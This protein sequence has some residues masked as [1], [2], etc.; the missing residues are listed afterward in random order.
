MMQRVTRVVWVL[1]LACLTMLAACDSKKESTDDKGAKATNA[2]KETPKAS[3]PEEEMLAS[4]KE[5]GDLLQANMDDAQK[6]IDAAREYH[7]KNEERLKGVM[8]AMKAKDAS[9]SPDDQKKAWEDFAAR[10]EY[11]HFYDQMDQFE[12]RYPDRIVE[13]EELMNTVQSAGEEGRVEVVDNEVD[14]AATFDAAEKVYGE[15]EQMS[16]TGSTADELELSFVE[17]STKVETAYARY[18]KV[19]QNTTDA[20]QG[21]RSLVRAAELH[22]LVASKIEEMPAV[23]GLD[24]ATLEEA[25]KRN[26]EP[27]RARALELF[28]AAAASAAEKG[29]DNDDAKRAAA[30]VSEAEQQQP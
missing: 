24:P 19:F 22:L 21:L 23:E 25:K 2:P 1:L 9:L 27:L 14:V 18:Q 30:A 20:A 4:M 26:V 16:L 6:A 29:I 12:K 11:N 15:I 3:G 5:V 8:E 28:K 7:T 17:I 10:S 13:L